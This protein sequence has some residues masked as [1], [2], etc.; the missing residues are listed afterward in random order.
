M[1]IAR[2]ILICFGMIYF[3]SS[4][5]NMQTNDLSRTFTEKIAGILFRDFSAMNNDIQN[6]IINEL[7]L[8]IRKAAHF[9]VYLIM[10]MFIYAE[11]ALWLKK[12]FLSGIIS[13]GICMIYAAADE[14]HQ[15]LVPGRTPLV[16]D[17]FIDSCGALIGSIICFFIIC[18]VYFIRNHREK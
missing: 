11:A 16:K 15:S 14:F 7:N 5:D 18:A 9:S 6:T 17:V 4:Q 12:Y 8:F 3:F 2:P 10:S 1:I 13:V